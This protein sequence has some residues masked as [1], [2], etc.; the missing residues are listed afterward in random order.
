MNLEEKYDLNKML[1]EIDEDIDEQAK[2]M[3]QHKDI[4]QDVITNLMIE[5]LKKK[6]KQMKPDNTISNESSQN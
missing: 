6:R 3:S 5:N 1:A 2:D 4:P